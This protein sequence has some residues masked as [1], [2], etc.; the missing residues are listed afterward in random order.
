MCK[1]E[2]YFKKID[3]HAQKKEITSMSCK[4]REAQ[5]VQ[6]SGMGNNRALQIWLKKF[7]LKL[8]VGLQSKT[9]IYP[10]ALNSRKHFSPLEKNVWLNLKVFNLPALYLQ[11]LRSEEG[12]MKQYGCEIFFFLD[13]KSG[14]GSQLLKCTRSRL[15]RKS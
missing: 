1:Q 9:D 14:S 7:L 5:A 13:S 3:L 2:F 11:V 6:S 8:A 4:H 10:N 15:N 12:G